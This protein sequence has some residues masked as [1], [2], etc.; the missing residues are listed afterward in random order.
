MEA[1][2][3]L[4]HVDHTELMQTAKWED[5][6]RLCDDAVYYNTASICIPPAYVKQAAEYLGDKMAVCTVIGFPHG[7]NTTACK[8]FEVKDAIANG[9]KEVDMVINIGWAKDGKF[10][11]ITEE[12]KALKEAAGDKILKVII[13]TGLLTDEE[14]IALC[15]CVTDAGADFIK[16]CT[17]FAAGKATV[18]DIALFKANIGPNVKMKASSGM[19]S[20][21]EGAV[22]VEMGCERLGSKLLVNIAKADGVAVEGGY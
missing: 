22:F 9:A 20:I 10:D 12:I 19:T 8:V 18:E 7:Y 13:E 17:G 4:K 15:K 5:I 1:R 2:E 6:K 14:K 3:V 16:T 11:A 21:D